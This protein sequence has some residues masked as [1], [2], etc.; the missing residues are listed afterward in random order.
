MTGSN[1]GVKR[2]RLPRGVNA[3]RPDIALHPDTGQDYLDAARA[4][5]NLSVSLY[6][7]RLRAQ[8]VAEYGALPILDDS[9]EVAHTAA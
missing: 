6:L 4:S 3:A 8:L 2:N 5:G 1:A 7:E 9:L